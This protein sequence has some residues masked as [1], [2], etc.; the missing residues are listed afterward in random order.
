ML[1]SHV[2]HVRRS[3][4]RDLCLL[5]Q[6]C[7]WS[8]FLYGPPGF[9]LKLRSRK[10]NSYMVFPFWPAFYFRDDWYFSLQIAKYFPLCQSMEEVDYARRKCAR[11]ICT[12]PEKSYHVL[13]HFTLLVACYIFI[14][15]SWTCHHHCFDSP[16][17]LNYFFAQCLFSAEP[18]ATLQ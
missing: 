2:D 1:L 3:I 4:G 11:L 14:F 13:S 18:I 6:I 7:Y 10:S 5:S 15:L 12:A 17:V 16:E 9:A 8:I